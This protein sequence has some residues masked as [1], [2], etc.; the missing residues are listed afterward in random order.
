MR[1]EAITV[2]QYVAELPP[3]RRKAIESVRR[4]ACENLPVGFEEAMNWGMISYQVPLTRYPNTHNKQPLMYAALASKKNHMALYLAG[5]YSSE[6]ARRDFEK[7]YRATGKPFDVGKSCV[8]FKRV[9]D[10]P[11][12]LT[13]KTIASLQV[14]DLVTVTVQVHSRGTSRKR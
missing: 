9:E 12:K 4:V 8:R 2:K 7:A 3:D 10:L 14:E 5:I 11:L 6:E 1:S 13:G